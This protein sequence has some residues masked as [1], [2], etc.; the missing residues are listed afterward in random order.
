MKRALVPVIMALI[1]IP[2]FRQL[3][4][5]PLLFLFFWSAL[6]AM[7]QRQM[8]ANAKGFAVPD[9]IPLLGHINIVQGSRRQY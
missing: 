1:L 3:W 8:L 4:C 6:V 2:Y 5:I 9:F 7:D